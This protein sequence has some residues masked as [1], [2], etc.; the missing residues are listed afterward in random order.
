MAAIDS[1]LD[2]LEHMGFSAS[3]INIILNLKLR[4]R[5]EQEAL[6]QIS[7]TAIMHTMLPCPVTWQLL[8]QAR[9]LPSPSTM[10]TA[11]YT[12]YVTKH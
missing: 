2:Q 11:A 1:V 10:Q 5:A 4:E 7:A 8:T 9:P 12:Q 3:E 6:V